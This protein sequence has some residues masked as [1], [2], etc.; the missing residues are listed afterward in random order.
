MTTLSGKTILITGASR[1]I[2]HAIAE[3][4]A[5]AGA[6]LAIFAKD[7]NLQQIQ[8]DLE[9]QGAK[10][11][12]LEVDIRNDAAVDAAIKQTAAHFNGID[13]LIN[14][15]SAFC[16]HHT[17]TTTPEEFDLVYS[18]NPRGTFLLSKV[19]FPYLKN[20]ANPHILNIA[21]PLDMDARWFKNHLA[22]SM[23]KISMS[24]CTLGMAEEFKKA[25]IGV[26]S[27]WP[28][29]TIATTTIK[30]HFA[31]EVYQGSRWPAIMADAAYAILCREAKQCTG[32]FFIDE[33]V[34]REA[35]VTD[36]TPY[37]VDPNAPLVLD[38]FITTQSAN[39][40]TSLGTKPI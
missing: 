38:L 25:G 29:T 5:K 28:Q 12:M 16:F 2:G 33:Q 30:D 18:I 15:A 27:L 21:P 8:S 24:M 19:C 4:C 20:A 14:N 13:V 26:N 17:E 36:F 1:G 37:A 32:N 22:F 3:R 35:G 6:N 10:V 9:K 39:L 40:K 11:L 7:G 34:L 23:S 31:P